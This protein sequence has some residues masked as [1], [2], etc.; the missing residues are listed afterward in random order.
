MSWRWLKIKDKFCL[1]RWLSWRCL[2]FG[3]RIRFLLSVIC[4]ES[5]NIKNARGRMEFS[6]DER[7][8]GRKSENWSNFQPVCQFLL[9][10]WSGEIIIQSILCSYEK[11]NLIV[12]IF[13][14]EIENE[15]LGTCL[16]NFFSFVTVFIMSYKSWKMKMYV[17]NYKP[18][19]FLEEIYR[20]IHSFGH[21]KEQKCYWGRGHRGTFLLLFRLPWLQKL[22]FW[23]FCYRLR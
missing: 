3:L 1:I 16:W 14:I 4:Q 19:F 22:Y 13:L 7:I 21:C 10:L 5:E 2:T 6:T 15:N 9:S 18:V 11:W 17:F 20:K 23:N 8:S 12:G